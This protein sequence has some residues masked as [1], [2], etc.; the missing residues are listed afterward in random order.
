MA[1]TYTIQ[2]RLDG[3]NDYTRS[4]RTNAYEGADCKKKNQRIFRIPVKSTHMSFL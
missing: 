2:G 3:L 1:V 4:C